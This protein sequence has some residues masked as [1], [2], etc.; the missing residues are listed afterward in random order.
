ML[1]SGRLYD[2][3]QLTVPHWKQHSCGSSSCFKSCCSSRFKSKTTTPSWRVPQLQPVEVLAIA[4]GKTHPTPYVLSDTEWPQKSMQTSI[5]VWVHYS[6]MYVQVQWSN[7]SSTS[8]ISWVDW[9]IFL[10]QAP[11]MSRVPSNCEVVKARA[12]FRTV[13]NPTILIYSKL[14]LL[15]SASKWSCWGGPEPHI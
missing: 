13:G 3:P 1:T 2:I 9:N 8:H 14:N 4:L 11:L 5:K 6:L 15:K 7:D 12:P 10:P